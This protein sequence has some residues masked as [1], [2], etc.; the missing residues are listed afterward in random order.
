MNTNMIISDFANNISSIFFTVFEKNISLGKIDN[1]ALRWQ[2]IFG[3]S[4][5]PN[6]IF[7]YLRSLE[8][9]PLAERE[10]AKQALSRYIQS[11]LN[12]DFPAVRNNTENQPHL[13]QVFASEE[14]KKLWLDKGKPSE[15]SNYQIAFSDN[16]M[17]L[18][19]IGTEIQGSCQHIVHDPLT[20]KCLISYLMH[21]GILPI[22]ARPKGPAEGKM[23][24]RCFLR[25]G[26]DKD[27]QSAVLLQEPIYSNVKDA[28]L[29][30]AINQMAV[31]KA[32]QLGIPLIENRARAA[33]GAP[34]KGTFSFLGSD[35][36]FVYS[37]SARGIV[38]GIKGFEIKDSYLVAS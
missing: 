20:N 17:D 4:R 28:A 27:K 13:T 31:D 11:V 5:Y 37:D 30:Q 33:H 8:K 2:K 9:L 3:K 12:G 23:V 7:S 19:L 26:W 18:R 10:V 1:F 21:G 35:Y 6:A 15:V 24:A 38:D 34:Y 36:P 29:S 32:K 25:L 22:V 16:F 14:M